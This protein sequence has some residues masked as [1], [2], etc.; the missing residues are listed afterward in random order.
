MVHEALTIT[1]EPI[2]NGSSMSTEKKKI[3]YIS[4]GHPDI[5]PGGGEIAA[6]NLFS[7]IK[8]TAGFDSCFLARHD[9]FARVHGGTTFS[10]T[11][12]Q[13]EI[14]FYAP[15][16]DWFQFSQPDKPKIW[17]DFRETLEIY[18]PDM[19]H[20]H[21]YVHLGLEMIREV[22]NFNK[23]IPVVLTLHEYF[24]ICHN[25]GQMIKTTDGSL[26]HGSS[27][28]DCA[29]CF[30]QYS[31]QDFFLRKQFIQSYFSLVDQFI[32]PSEFLRDR[33]IDWGLPAE[34]IKVIENIDLSRQEKHGTATAVKGTAAKQPGNDRQQAHHNAE[35]GSF[36]DREAKN[37]RVRFSFFGQINWFKGIDV[38]I[39]ALGFLPE[40]T[41][42]KITINING[43]GLEHQTE[44]M[45]E[46]V[47]KSIQN[48]G[49]I[50]RLRGKYERFELP[51]L[52]RS[53]DW[54][55]I[56]SKW[57]ENSP[58]VILEAKKYGVPVIC[59]NIGGMAEKVEH[60][61]TGLHFQSGRADSLA[62]QMEWVVNNRQVQQE[63]ATNMASNFS[64]SADFQSHL[65]VYEALLFGVS[66][67]V[68]LKA[69]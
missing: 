7:E 42:K 52:M 66:K 8:Q 17:R 36:I 10:G 44:E 48:S 51:G 61:V 35:I 53:T 2:F 4:H 32:S 63:F 15:M 5:N 23:K 26:C 13:N 27:P 65:D 6:Y 46:Y 47:R 30:P 14:L 29:R 55:V 59:S 18:Q 12:K 40:K 58:M 50:I 1:V 57:W 11:G 28:A 41:R 69:A 31:P 20:F 43:S 34:K 33:Y 64:S 54:I 68:S 38:L 60:G 39:D 9:K 22:K 21:H 16:A 67:N 37:N 19:I 3:L 25:H 49:G 56:P 45:Q 24:G 62:E